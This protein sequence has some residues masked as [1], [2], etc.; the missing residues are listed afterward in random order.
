[1]TAFRLRSG[2][3]T[4]VV[5][6]GSL[7]ETAAAGESIPGFDG[8]VETLS[9]KADAGEAEAQFLLGLY[10]QH[11]KPMLE[12]G[13]PDYPRAVDLYSRAAA[14][15][16]VGASFALGRLYDSGLGANKDLH[17]AIELYTVAAKAG[18]AEAMGWLASA[19]V[20]TG[21]FTWASIWSR[22]AAELGDPGGTNALGT[23]YHTGLGDVEKDF[24]KAMELYARAADAGHCHAIMNIGGLYYNGDG[25][26]Q[27][28]REAERWFNKA[29]SCQSDEAGFI[30]D[31][32]DK[33]LKK[34][35]SG[36]MPEAEPVGRTPRNGEL[37]AGATA[38]AVIAAAAAA[39][40]TNGPSTS[41]G[42]NP[43]AGE[44]KAEFWCYTDFLDPDPVNKPTYCR[45]RSGGVWN[46][47]GLFDPCAGVD[48]WCD[49]YG[50]GPKPGLYQ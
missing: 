19:Y 45:N 12:G 38:I 1:M 10:L 20:G 6:L 27:D 23:L 22:R 7:H 28:G 21:D 39:A 30:A 48:G 18:H 29:R 37:L 9:A 42:E 36:H 15:G 11:S 50:L 13:S 32:T 25:V 26:M 14:Q 41:A 2:I 31:Y 40:S 34:I 47:S 35:R 3:L 49:G 5:L 16:H 33:F 4:L 17:R 43:P 44:W 8:A 24:G 46:R